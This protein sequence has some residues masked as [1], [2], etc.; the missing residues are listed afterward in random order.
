MNKGSKGSL[1]NLGNILLPNSND[2]LLN[3]QCTIMIYNFHISCSE[4][5]LNYLPSMLPFS[6]L[7]SMFII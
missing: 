5:F 3:V 1:N 4:Y 2:G 6:Y 7:L